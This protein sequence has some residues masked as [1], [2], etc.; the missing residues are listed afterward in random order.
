MT[1]LWPTSLAASLWAPLKD[2]LSLTMDDTW[3]NFWGTDGG[4]SQ[5]SARKDV[6]RTGYVLGGGLEYAIPHGPSKGISILRSGQVGLNIG[7]RYCRRGTSA[8]TSAAIDHTYHSV[9]LGL[10]Y[11]I[12][13]GDAPLS[14]G[15]SLMG[16]SG[17][18]QRWR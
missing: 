6:I 16:M 15:C 12:S 5:S 2:R 14:R 1:V 13:E 7:R 11:H 17:P 18:R 8:Q 10:N 4:I 9:R 3:E